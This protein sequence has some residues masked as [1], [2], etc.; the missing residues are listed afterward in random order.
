ME[1]GSKH[2][3]SE[4]E[5]SMTFEWLSDVDT[6]GKSQNENEGVALARAVILDMTENNEN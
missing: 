5:L 6:S 1:S 3:G 4:T 2:E